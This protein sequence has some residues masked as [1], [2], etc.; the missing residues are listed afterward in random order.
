MLHLN[1]LATDLFADPALPDNKLRT[2]AS[3]HLAR[4]ANHNTGGIHDALIDATSAAYDAYYGGMTTEAVNKAVAEGRTKAT[5]AA[6][7][8]LKARLRSQHGLVIYLFGADSGIYQEFYPKGF[9][10]FHRASLDVLGPMLVSYIASANAHLLPDHAAEVTA[11]ETLASAYTDARAAQLLSKGNRDVA[12]SAR[13][14]ARK[15]LSV[16]LTRNFLILASQHVDDTDR[17]DDL[18]D[19]SLL[20]MYMKGW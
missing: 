5:Q 1:R 15:A 11:I 17:F 18:Y 10:A 3:D 14:A 9:N 7:N 6:K 2:F 20:P 4:L 12:A 19:G 13:R 16:Q 8:A